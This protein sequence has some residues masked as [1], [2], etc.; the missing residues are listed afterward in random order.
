LEGVRIVGR[1][2]ENKERSEAEEG[3]GGGG[4]GGGHAIKD[5]STH[6]WHDAR[7]ITKELSMSCEFSVSKSQ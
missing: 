4:G 5:G 1:G 2:G 3:G 7:K 6:G